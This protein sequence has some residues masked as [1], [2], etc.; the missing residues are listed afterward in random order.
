VSTSTDSLAAGARPRISL[1]IPCY[2]EE[3]SVDELM[4]EVIQVIERHRLDA[5]V[6]MRRRRLARQDLGQAG[7]LGP[8]PSRG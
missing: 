4:T 7:R 8:R 6:I 1:V 2:N 3:E 5:E